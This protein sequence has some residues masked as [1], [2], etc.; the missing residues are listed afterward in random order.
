M[1][2]EGRF[3]IPLVRAR[4]ELP[5]NLMSTLGS[6]ATEAAEEE[7]AELIE[8]RLAQRTSC[9]ANK[10]WGRERCS[11]LDLQTAADGPDHL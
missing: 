9:G 10:S 8:R 5:G 4:A 1:G 7:L 6:E 2:G 11:A 3:A